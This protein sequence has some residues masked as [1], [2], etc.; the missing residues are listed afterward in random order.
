MARDAT[1]TET[2]L[3]KAKAPLWKRLVK[4]RVLMLMVL[5]TVALVLAFQYMSMYGII[6]AFKRYS[7]Y[8][9]FLGSPWAKSSGFEHFIDFFKS[10]DSGLVIRNTVVIALLKLAILSFPPVILA[11]MLNE[12]NIPW[13][14]KS[15]QTVSYL[16]HFVAWVVVA[17][18]IQTAL[19]INFGPVNQFLMRIGAVEEPIYFLAKKN[20]FWPMI[21]ISDLW[22][23]VGWGSIIY[24]GVISGINPNLYE[25]AEID[26]AKRMQKARFITWPHLM[27]TF[28][29]LFILACGSIMQGGGSTFEQSYILGNKLIREVSDILD[30]YILRIGLDQGRFS[31]G[32]AV[33]LFKAVVNLSLLLSAN[34]ISRRL[35]GRGLF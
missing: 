8:K 6:I 34:W 32:T 12:I 24:L 14:R 4:Y 15:F 7:P 11:I 23:G 5:P 30:T 20:F 29:I 35:S 27:D 21:I 25:A 2:Q 19:N 31:F 28:V 13:L 18:M 26:G 17:G 10:P 9:G 16:P 3:M 1:L 22:K 33:G